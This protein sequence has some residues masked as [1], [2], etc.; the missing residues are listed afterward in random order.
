MEDNESCLMHDKH[1]AETTSLGIN[2]KVCVC[3]RAHTHKTSP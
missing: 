1:H 3:V 2:H